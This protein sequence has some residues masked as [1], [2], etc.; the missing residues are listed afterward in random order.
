MLNRIYLLAGILLFSLA[1]IHAQKPRTDAN[2]VGHV[3]CEGMHVPFANVALKGTTLGTVTDETGHFQLINL[4]AGPQVI[5]VSMVGYKP[6]E[7]A[8]SLVAN[9]VVEINFELEKD[10]MDLEEVVVSADR[11]EQKRIEA[12]LIVTRF[13][14]HPV[15]HPGRRTQLQSRAPAGK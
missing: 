11:S 13:Q 10:I 14:F 1:G 9:R 3:V 12:P 4:P 6:Q 2:V 5:A 15:P 8:I 7:K